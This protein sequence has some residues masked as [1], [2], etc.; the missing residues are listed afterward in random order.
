MA[1]SWRRAPSL[2]CGPAA[3]HWPT[4]TC[5]SH[6]STLT[7]N[8]RQTSLLRWAR[9]LGNEIWI[10]GTYALGSAEL[11]W[12]QL[13]GCTKQQYSFEASWLAE[14]SHKVNFHAGCKFNWKHVWTLYL[15]TTKFGVW[16]GKSTRPLQVCIFLC[17]YLHRTVRVP[18]AY[19][20]FELKSLKLT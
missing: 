17:L 19:T 1:S 20:H 15:H 9:E 5:Q 7:P 16:F 8:P 3:R 13:I 6:P 11:I 12:A 4:P 2:T 14:C 10:M 18:F